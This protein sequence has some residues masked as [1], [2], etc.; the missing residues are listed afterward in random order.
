MYGFL[1]ATFSCYK[2]N[3]AQAGDQFNRDW[4]FGLPGVTE[5]EQSRGREGGCSAEPWN[6]SWVGW[7]GERV[8]GGGRELNRESFLVQNELMGTEFQFGMAFWSRRVATVT[9]QCECTFMPLNCT[10]KNLVCIFYHSKK[11]NI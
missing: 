11:I 2:G 1:L 10:L 8:G 7:Q 4:S 3:K 6:V 5:E 9:Q